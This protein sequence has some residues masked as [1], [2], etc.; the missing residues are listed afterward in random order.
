MKYTRCVAALL[1]AVVMAVSLSTTAIATNSISQSN[2]L[3]E[4]FS[5]TTN[6]IDLTLT[7]SGTTA[8]CTALIRG[9]TNVNRIVANFTLSRV[10]A[11]GTSTVVRTWSNLTSSTRTLTF[12]GTFSPVSRGQTYRLDLVATVTTTSGITETVRGSIT[13]TY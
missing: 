3:I 10:N 12:S 13:R 1:V 7:Y 6:S 8:T 4:P 9:Q 11:N 5:Q 2:T